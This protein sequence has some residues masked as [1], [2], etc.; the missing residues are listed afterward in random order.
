[1]DAD[2]QRPL[3]KSCRVWSLKL[4]NIIALT[5]E[6][7]PF[8]MLLKLPELKIDKNSR[9]R[10]AIDVLRGKVPAVYFDK[11]YGGH[12][13]LASTA[14]TE[15]YL[16]AYRGWV[17]GAV[18]IVANTAAAGRLRFYTENKNGQKE[19]LTAGH[20]LVDLFKKPNMI[21]TR[22]DLWALS[23]TWLELTG[24]AYWL[25]IRDRL[26]VT[27]MLL[28]LQPNWIKVVPDS[29]EIIG[30]YLYENGSKKLAFDKSE[31]VYVRYPNPYELWDGMGPL[32][33][34]SYSYDSDLSMHKY[35]KK[36]FENGGMIKGVLGTDQYMDEDSAK[37]LRD[38]WKRLYGG[39]DNAKSVAVLHSGLSYTPVELSPNDLDFTQGRRLTRQEIFAI[40]GVSEGLLGMV[41]DVNKTNNIQLLDSFLRFTMQPKAAMI[42][43]RIDM[44]LTDDFDTKIQTEF[45]LPRAENVIESMQAMEY[46]LKNYV[47]SVNEERENIGYEAVD[48]GKKPWGPFSLVQLGSANISSKSTEKNAVDLK[49]TRSV[50][51]I[52]ESDK[53]LIWRSFLTVHTPQ[54]NNFNKVMLVYFDRQRDEVLRNLKRASRSVGDFQKRDYDP[55]LVESVLFSLEDWNTQLRVDIKPRV[56]EAI[57][58]AAEKALVDIASDGD[59]NIK[60]PFVQE[61]VSN[62]EFVLPPQINQLTHDNLRT[63][64]ETGLKDNLSVDVIAENIN[65]YFDGMNPIRAMRIA[66]TEVTSASNFGIMESYRQVGTVQT[67]AW[68]TARDEDVRVAHL[69]VE[70]ESIAN[71]VPVGDPF[72][73]NGVAM[74]YPGD[75]AGPA[76]EVINCRCTVVPMDME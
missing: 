3:L 54:E 63:I 23:F 51:D 43:E 21:Q 38:D 18:R 30:G 59:F 4:C 42:G 8:G 74:M 24:K 71:P 10:A 1:V 41:E 52:S 73:V 50:R 9:L 11:T 69:D 53:D 6:K 48:W 19:Y 33:A 7:Q 55:A 29:S 49:V 22:W 28:P 57:N 64:L 14:K 61:F 25:K 15:D 13:G 5:V 37:K 58:A 75:S 47:T 56:L 76:S 65:E 60:D 26:G 12:Y 72:I 40:F 45:E 16:R 17:Y 44:D 34:A 32:Q 68:I 36:L 27:R 67:R 35:D 46:R 39:T 2:R 62:K 31:I 70:Q 20:P 66:R